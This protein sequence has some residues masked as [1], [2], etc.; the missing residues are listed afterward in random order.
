M[1]DLIIRIINWNVDGKFVTAC[2]II[3]GRVVSLN[4]NLVDLTFATI[5]DI[6]AGECQYIIMFLES[7]TSMKPVVLKLYSTYK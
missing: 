3:C 6:L 7:I 1:I 4:I 5:K 2:N